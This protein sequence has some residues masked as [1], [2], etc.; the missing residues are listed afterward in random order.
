MARKKSDNP[1]KDR[2]AVRLTEAQADRAEDLIEENVKLNLALNPYRNFG[3]TD[4][5][6]SML[7]EGGELLEEKLKKLLTENKQKV[8]NT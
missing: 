2:L 7:I 1:K 5:I 6:R 3:R 4:A 8:N